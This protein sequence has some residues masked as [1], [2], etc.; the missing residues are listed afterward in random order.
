MEHEAE[1]V[2]ACDI[3]AAMTSLILHKP[4]H[5]PGQTGKGGADREIGC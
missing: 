1:G 3:T 5:S 2:A 4:T